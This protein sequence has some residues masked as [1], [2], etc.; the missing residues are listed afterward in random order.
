MLLVTVD[1]S[2]ARY[3]QLV[4]EKDYKFSRV[5][6]YLKTV[7]IIN[8]EKEQEIEINK[9]TLKVMKQVSPSI[10]KPDVVKYAVQ[11]YLKKNPKKAE[12]IQNDELSKDDMD[13]L[14]VASIL[15]R[16]SGDLDKANRLSK[17][18]PKKNVHTAVK[19]VS[20]Q[21][22]DDLLKKQPSVDLSTSI[23]IQ[24]QDV[25]ARVDGKTPEHIFDKRRIDFETNLRK[26]MTNAFRV[27]EGRDIP[28]KFDSISIKPKAQKPGELA[29]S[30]EAIVVIKLKDKK[31]RI[32]E[33]N[34]SIPRIDPDTGTFRV[35]GKRKCLI[36]QIVLNPIS[37][38]KA[39]DSKFESSYSS[40]H[41][42]SK[43]TKRLK[44]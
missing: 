18:I 29:Q 2:S 13:R 44:Y 27:L 17:L 25:P 30:D 8:T 15:Y 43:R 35:N 1:E 26:D 33:V 37:F 28:L 41:I 32:Q 11:D 4:K 16:A 22:E 23:V 21:Y 40:F 10:D 24:E 42:Y 39:Y 9:A 34:L 20:K 7:K 5:L 12:K 14:T 6:Q 3:R 38:P 19:K 31:G 36:N